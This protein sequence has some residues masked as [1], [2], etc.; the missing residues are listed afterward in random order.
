MIGFAARLN[1]NFFWLTGSAENIKLYFLFYENKINIF[2]AR[3]ILLFA[4]NGV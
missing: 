4:E 2:A 3:K 1:M